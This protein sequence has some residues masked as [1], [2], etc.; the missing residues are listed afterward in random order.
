MMPPPLRSRPAE[1][2]VVA[3]RE[4][5]TQHVGLWFALSFVRPEQG[6]SLPLSA[7]AFRSA[8]VGDGG[9]GDDQLFG[10]FLKAETHL[11]GVVEDL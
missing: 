9:E 8:N 1:V 7:A 2:R 6:T 4:P 3:E 10:H 5:A 11:E